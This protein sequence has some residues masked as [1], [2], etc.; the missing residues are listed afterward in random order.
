MITRV[1]TTRG[2]RFTISRGF[3]IFRRGVNAVTY[4]LLLPLLVCCPLLMSLDLIIWL[5]VLRS[6]RLSPYTSVCPQTRKFPK[7]FGLHKVRSSYLVRIFNGDPTI[8]GGIH[9]HYCVTLSHWSLCS[10]APCPEQ[11]FFSFFFFLCSLL[12]GEGGL[13]AGVELGIG[14]IDFS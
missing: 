14:D 8:S 7:T 4:L 1:I 5:P 2:K 10:H 11:F 12:V 13:I 6:P 3:V 9:L